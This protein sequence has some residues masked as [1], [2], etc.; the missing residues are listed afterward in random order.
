MTLSREFWHSELEG[1]NIEHPLLLPVDRHR[2]SSDQR[3]GLASLVEISFDNDVSKSF[4][5]Y[6]S[7]SELTPFQLGLAIFYTFLFKLTHGQTDLCISC[8]NANRYR[9]EIQNVLGVFF[10]TLPYRF[11]VDA[12]WSFDELARNVREKCLSI[13]EHSH[14]PLQHILANLHFNP[15]DI[16]FLQSTFDL[17]TFSSEA[18]NLSFNGASLKEM[19][20]EQPNEVAKVDF[21]VRFAYD[22]TST[23]NQLLCHFICSRDLFDETVVKTMALRLQ[24]LSRQLFSSNSSTSSTDSHFMPITA[25]DLTLFEETE[26]INNVVFC[27]QPIVNNEGM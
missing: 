10:S 2:L 5:N 4:L 18:N 12:Y 20:M 8:L 15:L 23:D 21:S 17:I 6:A 13:L 27:R 25:L 7:S 24:H 16:P 11:Q 1:Y 26:E 9:S 19:H 3:S 22:P 14:Y